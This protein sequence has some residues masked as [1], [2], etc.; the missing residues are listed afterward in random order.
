MKD[1]KRE[2][3]GLSVQGRTFYI[4][5]QLHLPYI[6]T[7]QEGFST[8]PNNPAG[9]CAGNFDSSAPRNRKDK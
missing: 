9:P 6:N 1:L 2:N 8:K 4:Y 5:T 7:G 3:P